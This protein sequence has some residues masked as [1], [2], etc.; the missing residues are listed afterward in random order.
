MQHFGPPAVVPDAEDGGQEGEDE[1][2][3]D[4]GHGR[5]LARVLVGGRQRSQREDLGPM[6]R[7]L[8]DFFVSILAI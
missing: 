4:D 5:R 3:D 7:F 6:L 8:F 1:D 2:G